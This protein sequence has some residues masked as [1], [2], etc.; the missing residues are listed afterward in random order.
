MMVYISTKFHEN[1][2]N[3]IRVMEQTQKVNRW[4]A[5]RHDKN[6]KRVVQ[7]YCI[8]AVVDELE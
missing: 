4:T 7:T 5:G 8:P 3:G 2:L 1:I 6:F